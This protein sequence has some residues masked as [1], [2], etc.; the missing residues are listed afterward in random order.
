MKNLAYR[1]RMGFNQKPT[2]RR[3]VHTLP[4]SNNSHTNHKPG[5]ALTK[6]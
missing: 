2:E 4:S 5:T 6:F 3:R 1:T